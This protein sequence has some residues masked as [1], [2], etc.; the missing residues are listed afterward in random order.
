[1]CQH[2]I[3]PLYTDEHTVT[4]A[5]ARSVN[6][7]MLDDLQLITGKQVKLVQ[8]AGEQ[9]IH[10]QGKFTGDL[11]VAVEEYVLYFHGAGVHYS[12]ACNH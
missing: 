12:S 2:Q 7:F 3:L 1:M 4:V 10:F 6:L 8:A 11:S 5:I 9:I